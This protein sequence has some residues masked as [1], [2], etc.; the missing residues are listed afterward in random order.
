MG[1]DRSIGKQLYAA[2]NPE[3]QTNPQ[4]EELCN[5]LCIDD[6]LS[7]IDRSSLESVRLSDLTN[8]SDSDLTFQVTVNEDEIQLDDDSDDEQGVVG[9]NKD[10]VVS[11][12]NS[13]SKLSLPPPKNDGDEGPEDGA[14]GDGLFVIGKTGNTVLGF[15]S[16]LQLPPPKNIEKDN[17]SPKRK[18]EDVPSSEEKE[19]KETDEK[20]TGTK[21]VMKRRNIDLYSNNDDDDI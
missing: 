7:L 12:T 15:K 21:K 3:A 19:V 10:K 16:K 8:Q 17:N 11:E 18:A 4:T 2:R 1:D 5:I 6:P 20:Q 13:K 14:N 9:E